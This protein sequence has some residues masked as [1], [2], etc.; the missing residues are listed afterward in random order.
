V[1]AALVLAL[2][3]FAAGCICSNTTSSVDGGEGGG[4][5]GTGGGSGGAAGGAAAGTGGA[6]GGTGAD[7]G[8]GRTALQ[9][10]GG[11]GRMSGGGL[12]LDAQLGLPL[13]QATRSDAGD[14]LEPNPAIRP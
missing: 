14:T 13:Q 1:R 8:A 4:A 11:A 10:A 7:A 3:V 2:L 6:G 5:S 9:L 12:T